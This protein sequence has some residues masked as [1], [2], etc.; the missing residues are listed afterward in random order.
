MVL[1][2]VNAM[3]DQ[4]GSGGFEGKDTCIQE[5]AILQSFVS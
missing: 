4:A 2:F 1:I 5:S 3:S